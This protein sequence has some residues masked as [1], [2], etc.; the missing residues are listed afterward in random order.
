MK[1]DSRR[2]ASDDSAA[3]SRSSQQPSANG[4]PQR[5]RKSSRPVAK[6][7]LE[8]EVQYNEVTD[9]DNVMLRYKHLLQ[10][11]V[12]KLPDDL[13]DMMQVGPEVTLPS[14]AQ[15]KLQTMSELKL[16]Q[17]QSTYQH[18]VKSPLP[19]VSQGGRNQNINTT[20]RP[21]LPP[22]IAKS[23]HQDSQSSKYDNQ[24]NDDSNDDDD[25]DELLS[26]GPMS[27]SDDFLNSVSL[28]TYRSR[29][30]GGTTASHNSVR[31]A[32]GSDR[33][34]SGKVLR[35]NSIT[36]ASSDHSFLPSMSMEL[37]PKDARR[38]IPP[39]LVGAS[40][41]VPSNLHTRRF[42]LSDTS[43]NMKGT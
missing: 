13:S 22:V 39:R 40:K 35:T 4:S 21:P 15:Q 17:S 36:Q 19:P 27:N 33:M 24:Y 32:T 41:A 12:K 20:H 26:E 8:T 29:F 38:P 25:D 9:V 34:N 37:Q 11:R 16:Q 14:R 10:E 28:P 5:N 3:A 31:Y 6:T 30:G 18:T 43:K 1:R 42:P 2:P 7:I 23:N